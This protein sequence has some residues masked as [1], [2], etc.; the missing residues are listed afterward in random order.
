[1]SSQLLFSKPPYPVSPEGALSSFK[2]DVSDGD[3]QSLKTLLKLLPIPRPNWE[4]GHTDR[5]FG[6]P[7]DWLVEAVDY[8]QNT[9]DW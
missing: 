9:Y 2:I 6:T 8:W 4:N 1:M 7:R 5:R 3:L